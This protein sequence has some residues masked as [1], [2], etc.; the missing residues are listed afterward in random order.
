VSIHAQ[1]RRAAGNKT[2]RMNKTSGEVVTPAGMSAALAVLAVSG[3]V[4]GGSYYWWQGEGAHNVVVGAAGTVALLVTAAVVVL[5]VRAA[6]QRALRAGWWL[7][8]VPVFALGLVAGMIVAPFTA[9]DIEAGVFM[10]LLMGPLALGVLIWVALWS[11][12]MVVR[13]N[14]RR[15]AGRTGQPALG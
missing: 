13:G 11:T 7:D 15:L 5:F 1:Y 6:W 3:G 12:F 14:R 8:I 4:A 2:G 9:S 10:T